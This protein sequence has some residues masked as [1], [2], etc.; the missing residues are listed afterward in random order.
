[1]I[2]IKKNIIYEKIL[3]INYFLDKK[4]NKKNEKILYINYFLNKKKNNNI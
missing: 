3:Y 1:M 2:L 4:K